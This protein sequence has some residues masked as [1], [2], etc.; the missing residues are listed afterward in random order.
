[1]KTLIEIV[2][3]SLKYYSHLFLLEFQVME[4]ISCILYSAWLIKFPEVG[5][6]F[7]WIGLVFP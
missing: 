3:N 6:K 1:M 5:T 2:I 4:K 7:D